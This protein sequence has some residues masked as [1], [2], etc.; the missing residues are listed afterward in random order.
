MPLTLDKCGVS[1]GDQ[2]MTAV[3]TTLATR[4]PDDTFVLI[5][6]NSGEDP[7]TVG[8]PPNVFNPWT[9]L[10]PEVRKWMTANDIHGAL[11]I[12]QHRAYAAFLDQI[13]QHW[14]NIADAVVLWAGQHGTSNGPIPKVENRELFTKP[15]DAFAHYAGFLLRGVNHWRD[16]QPVARE[17]IWLN[18]DPRNYL[19]MRDL[20]WPLRH[21][22]LTQY[23]YTH[24]IK[25]ERH[26][27]GRE[28]FDTFVDHNVNPLFD[29]IGYTD[30][31]EVW[32][33]AV[34][35]VYS[36]L[37]LNLTVPGTPSGD[38]LRFNGS[39]WKREPFGIIINEA[40][41][42]GVRDDVKRLTAMREWVMPLKPTFIHGKWSEASQ[43]ELGVEIEPCEWRRYVTQVLPTVRA[44]FTTP[45]S[46]SG[47]ATTKPWEAFA[48]GVVCFFHPMYDT[49][50]HIL[51]DAPKFLRGWLRVKTPEELAERVAF[52]SN[53]D[54]QNV[55]HRLVEE[56][57]EHYARA[58]ADPLYVRMIE[59]RIY[60]G[61]K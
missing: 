37:E 25:H 6:R 44:T 35:N 53:V 46:G 30:H 54:G 14:F 39:W 40:R 15:Q 8:L 28:L 47:W 33:S 52:L 50:D 12:E 31:G 34:R 18:A 10:G 38:H 5:G 60:G 49:Q 36:R 4:H 20:K 29:R 45:S 17:E 42:V 32:K 55:W 11:T 27:A 56:Q 19:K 2:E 61:S 43:R 13:T 41:H 58:V 16:K 21:P 57:R 1:G 24:N 23:D 51:G 7:K 59:D 9:T 26:G 22:V 48:T 3:I